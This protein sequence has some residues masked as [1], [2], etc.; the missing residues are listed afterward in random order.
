MRTRSDIETYEAKANDMSR[1]KAAFESGVQVVSTD[2]ETV[3]GNV[4]GT[5]YI[6]RLPGSEPARCN[7]VSSSQ[8]KK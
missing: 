3:A 7:A 1:A 4:Y 5:S 2:Y 6:V 8:C